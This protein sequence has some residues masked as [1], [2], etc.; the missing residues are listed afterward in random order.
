V[1]PH[2][3]QLAAERGDIDTHHPLKDGPWLFRRTDLDRPAAKNLLPHVRNNPK[4]PAVPDPEQQKST[5]QSEHAW[6]SPDG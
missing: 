5:R 3:L 6:S 2:T 4:H 1:A